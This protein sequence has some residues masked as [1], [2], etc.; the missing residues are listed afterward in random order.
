MAKRVGFVSGGHQKN[1]EY[2]ISE[3]AGFNNEDWVAK[4]KYLS[5][6][7]IVHD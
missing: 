6:E 1:V 4:L 2:S 3:N 7:A 5:M